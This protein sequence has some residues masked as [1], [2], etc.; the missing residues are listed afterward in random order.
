MTFSIRWLLGLALCVVPAV[1]SAETPSG[2]ATRVHRTARVRRA[3]P[4]KEQP[5]LRSPVEVVAGA[6][7]ATFALSRCDGSPAPLAVDQI[8][9]LARP[10]SAARPKRSLASLARGHGADLAPGIRR[11]DEHLVERLGL[12]VEHFRKSGPQPVR[13]VLVSG[14]R[15]RSSGS[16]HAAGRALDFRLEGVTNDDVVSF[17]KTLTDT[18]CGFYPNG[19]FVHMDVRDPGAGHVAW[20]DI[21]RPGEAPKYVH[22]Y[23]EPPAAPREDT[24]TASAQPASAA[25]PETRSATSDGAAADGSA[26]ESL[27]SLPAASERDAARRPDQKGQK[28]VR[29][30]ARAY[31][32]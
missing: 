11:V 2:G 7:S 26:S 13:V 5:C 12:M 3:E 9:L 19:S 6:E 16:Y 22:D 18:G 4:T 32:F 29:I 8:S 21:S 30:D 15:P 14:Y 17:C 10:A 25:K 20:V 24:A 1:A 27:P 28:K 31:L 23:A